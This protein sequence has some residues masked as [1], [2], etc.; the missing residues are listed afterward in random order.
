MMRTALIEHGF[1][2]V[3]LIQRDLDTPIYDRVTRIADSV[4]KQQVRPHDV[5]HAVFART[6]SRNAAGHD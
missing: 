5:S 3:S 1:D 2:A 6:R 4:G